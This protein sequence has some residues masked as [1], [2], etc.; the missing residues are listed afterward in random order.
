MASAPG[1]WCVAGLWCRR[2]FRAGG[3]RRRLLAGLAV[4]PLQGARYLRG[5][6]SLVVL[7]EHLVGDE[8]PVGAQPSVRDDARALAKQVWQY[9]VVD[10]RHAVAEVG[11]DEVRLE[12]PRL[13]VEAPLG[14]HAA[15]AE[16]LP[17]RHLAGGHLG[18]IEVEHTF[19]LKAESASAPAMLT[20]A[21]MPMTSVMR[22]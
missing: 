4:A 14:H 15:E 19:F 12:T 9:L 7:G 5:H 18:G 22:R 10:D 21:T 3:R 20:P 17:A 2:A 8:C 11:H 1:R 16:A 13:T 6:V